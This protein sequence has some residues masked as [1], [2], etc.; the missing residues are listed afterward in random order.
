M[1]ENQYV[2]PIAQHADLFDELVDERKS[3]VNYQAEQQTKPP[4]PSKPPAPAPQDT[5]TLNGVTYKKEHL[6][7]LNGKPFVKPEYKSLYSSGFIYGSQTPGKTLGEEVGNHFST[8]L[9]KLAAPGMGLIDFGVDAATSVANR[10]GINAESI[11]RQWDNISRFESS[12]AQKLRKFSSVVLP[13]MVGAG[14]VGR[15]LSGTKLPFMA[16]AAVG[17]AGVAG[18]D[19]AIISVSDEGLEQDSLLGNLGKTFPDVFGNGGIMPMPTWTQ[20]QDGDSPAKTKLINKLDAAGTSVIGDIIGLGLSFGKPALNWFIPKNSAAQSYKAT[21]VIKADPETAIRIAEIDQALATQ[22]SRANAKVLNEERERLIAQLQDTGASEV[23]TKSDAERYIEV[24]EGSRRTQI[25]EE[26]ILKLEADPQ[27]FGQYVPEITPGLAS[28]GELARQTFQPG[29]IARNMADT[30]AIKMGATLGDPAPILS[31]PMLKRGLV[32][33]QSRKAVMGLAEAARQAGDFDAVVDGFRMTGKQMREAHAKIYADIIRAGDVEEVKRLFADDRNVATLIDGTKVKYLSDPQNLQAELAIRDLV[34]MYLGRNVMETSARVMDTLGR[35]INTIAQAQ[36][37]FEDLVDNDRIQEVILDKLEFLMQ[38]HGLNKYISGW[39][40]QNKSWFDRLTKSNNPG[41]LTELINDEFTQAVN[42]KHASVKRF[43]GE[44]KQLGQDNPEMVKPL[45][46][47]FSQSNGD[48]D[49]IQKLYKWAETQMSPMGMLLSADPRK[50]N[51]FARTLWGVAMNNVLSMTSTLNAIKGNLSKTIL[52]PIEGFIGHGIEAVIARDIEPIK[53]AMYYY[54]GVQETQKRALSDAITRIKRVN[55]DYDFMMSQIRDDYRI[56]ADKEWDLLDAVANQWKKDGNT[57]KM[58]QYQWLKASQAYSRMAWARSAMTGMSG[59][60]AYTDTIQATQLSR[61]RAY[62]E[63]FSGAGEITPELLAK[64]EKKHYSTMFNADGVLSDEAA[65]NASGE[66][67]L[68]L[69]D[70]V[71]SF[72]N[73]AVTAVPAAKMFFMFPKTAA[74][75]IKQNLSYTPIAVIPGMNKYAKVLNAGDDIDLIKEALAEHGIKSFESTPNAMAI[76]SKLK[77]EYI[78]RVVMGTSAGILAYGYAAAGNIR[79]NGPVN[80]AERQKLRDNYG[81]EPKTINIGGKWVSFKGIPMVDTILTL[82]GDLAFYQNDI[83]E[84]VAENIVDKLGW[85]L[86][87]TFTNNT[88]LHGIEPLIAAMNGDEASW[89]R[90][91][92]NMVRTF[93]PQ[94]GNLGIVSNAITSSQ[95]DIYNDMIGYI[96]NRIPIASSTLPEQI[97]FWTGSA[98]KDIENPFLRALNAA[99]PIKV[100]EGAEPWRKWLL[101]TGYDGISRLTTSSEGGYE[102]DAETRERLGRL[103]GEQKLYKKIEKLMTKER[104]NDELAQV[105]ALRQSGATYDEVKIKTEELTVYRE[106]DRIVS[107]AKKIAEARLFEERPE[108]PEAVYGQRQTD[109][110]MGRGDVRSA[111]ESADLTDQRVQELLKRKNR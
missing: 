109:I 61:L 40:L 108:I 105:R 5:V 52:Q 73:Q 50:M 8:M 111:K 69:D 16:K 98:L 64:A 36:K 25:D 34:D 93:I 7:Y 80:A 22:P 4:Q 57:G 110:L 84:S 85:T 33:G 97:D 51:L 23:T 11:N 18:T 99:S 13:S 3:Y 100:S 32:L 27:T 46:E 56:D 6:N 10:L 21:Q 89:S 91:T 1:P 95:K 94:S 83:G 2:D 101:S 66:V 47:A 103:I 37:E 63:V 107:E 29:N 62:D 86:A 26:A 38:E 24:A 88:P 79:G 30:A 59:V 28:P 31:G 35:E 42:A 71:A 102:Y 12:G 14:M 67:S 20:H 45:F 106:L 48:V 77:N 43:V 104:F 68:N 9:Q 60:D 82:V 96:K 78:G 17:A 90:L 87:A 41:E 15:A 65:K 54:G 58:Y 53:R 72:I 81:W 49:T 74:N 75:E 44:L 76:Y 19:V 70:G 55:H 92:A 39:Q